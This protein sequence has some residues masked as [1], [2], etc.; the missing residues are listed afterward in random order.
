[1]SNDRYVSDTNV[2]QQWTPAKKKWAAF[3]LARAE[4]TRISHYLNVEL[5]RDFTEVDSSLEVLRDISKLSPTAMDDPYST[6][7]LIHI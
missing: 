6:L 1:M 2:A 4:E 3:L 7:S 5:V